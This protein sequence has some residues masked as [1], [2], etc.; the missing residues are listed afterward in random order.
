MP[1]TA[2]TTGIVWAVFGHRLALEGNGTRSLADLGPKAVSEGMPRVGDAVTVE[3][4]VT[5]CEI[6]VSRL[7]LADGTVHII[8]RPEKG[9]GKGDPDAAVRLVR[10]AGYRVEGPPLRKLRHFEI[11]GIRD[12][13]TFDVH[14]HD[15]VGIRK[16][17]RI[18]V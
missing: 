13:E 4:E 5:P 16:E 1:K 15:D 8:A 11:R 12:G 9:H 17:K 14:V 10:D 6:K 7:V 3:G 2:T 18:A